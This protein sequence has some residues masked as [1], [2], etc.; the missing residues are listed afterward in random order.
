MEGRIS[1]DAGLAG[2]RGGFR[3]GAVR[4]GAACAWCVAQGGAAGI[5]E[6]FLRNIWHETWA[7]LRLTNIPLNGMWLCMVA[8]AD[9]V[10]QRQQQQQRLWRGTGRRGR[11]GM[12][13]RVWQRSPA[14]R[15]CAHMCVSVVVDT[16]DATMF[17]TQVRGKEGR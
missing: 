4:T 14:L 16:D 3:T 1:G 17:D 6:A 10:Q 9:A 11:V 7:A 2:A 12:A 13:A 5:A 8:T 15:V